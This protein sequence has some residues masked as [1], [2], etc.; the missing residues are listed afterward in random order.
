MCESELPDHISLEA[1]RN[2]AEQRDLLERVATM[3]TAV[4]ERAEQMLSAL[5]KYE[6]VLKEDRQ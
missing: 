4:S 3:N 2:A 5:E 6:H 1:L